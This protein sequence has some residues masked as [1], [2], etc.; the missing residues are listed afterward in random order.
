MCKYS[1]K[2]D[3]YK[4][5]SMVMEEIM[6][7]YYDP[8]I[9]LM[10]EEELE[11]ILREYG[12]DIVEKDKWLEAIIDEYYDPDVTPLTQE[13][14]EEILVKYGDETF[15]V[16]L[17][18]EESKVNKKRE[19]RR[20]RGTRRGGRCKRSEKDLVDVRLLHMNCDGYTSKKESIETDLKF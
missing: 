17:C 18:G 11:N 2:G 5:D 10:G 6:E 3:E 14:L 19:R 1:G 20:R 16:D 12:N 15:Q 7:E 8:D 13:E 9:S 4:E